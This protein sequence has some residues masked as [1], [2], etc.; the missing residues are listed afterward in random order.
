MSGR[1]A[2]AAD[3]LCAVTPA[4]IG[5]HGADG[6]TVRIAARAAGVSP[7]TAYTYYSSKNHLVA[8]SFARSLADALT[9][10]DPSEPP[11]ARVLHVLG[12]LIDV[13]LTDQHF[14]NAV[15]AALLGNEPDAQAVRV[16][17]GLLLR[18]RLTQALGAPAAPDLVEAIELVYSGVLVQAGMGYLDADACRRRAA[19]AVDL[20]MEA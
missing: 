19:R 2:D 18:D 1:Q 17:V 15:N 10:P 5:E 20:M 14:A 4:V 6:F 16:R 13:V 8:E 11:R 9:P 3:R 7:A 12:E